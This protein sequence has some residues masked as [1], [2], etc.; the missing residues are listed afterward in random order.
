VWVGLKPTER[1]Q[2]SRGY[3]HWGQRNMTKENTLR[4]GCKSLFKKDLTEPTFLEMSDKFSGI[5]KS[6]W[7]SFW[8]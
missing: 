7:T 6:V 5:N 4:S 1:L 2:A 8:H 3:R